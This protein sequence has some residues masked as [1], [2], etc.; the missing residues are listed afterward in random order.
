M[1]ATSSMLSLWPCR[2]AGEPGQIRVIF[3]SL[4]GLSRQVDLPANSAGQVTV[5]QLWEMVESA[6][7][8]DGPTAG[9]LSLFKP[10]TP[11]GFDDEDISGAM[12]QVRTGKMLRSSDL[13]CM[14]SGLDRS[15][16]FI[17]RTLFKG[18]LMFVLP[19]SSPAQACPTCQRGSC[20]A[21]CCTAV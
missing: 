12:D 18:S 6:F 19:T 8:P 1:L 15:R 7:V 21:Q 2:I 16:L 13:P 20:T 14:A 5:R 17:G 4:A 9:S 11:G 3:E 10:G